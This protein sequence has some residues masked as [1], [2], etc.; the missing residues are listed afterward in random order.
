LVAEVGCHDLKRF[1]VDSIDNITIDDYVVWLPV[2]DFRHPLIHVDP[3]FPQPF[4][5]LVLADGVAFVAKEVR[6]P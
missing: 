1:V 4:L 5:E 2:R 3:A 6:R